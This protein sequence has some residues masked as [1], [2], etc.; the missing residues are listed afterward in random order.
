MDDELL[1]QGIHPCTTPA[2]SFKHPLALV[3]T[4]F[5]VLYIVHFLTDVISASKFVCSLG[6]VSFPTSATKS[7]RI[8]DV[9]TFDI[10]EASMEE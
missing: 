6:S 7:F 5:A 8:V 1:L 2:I 10:G 9:K 3:C 4:S